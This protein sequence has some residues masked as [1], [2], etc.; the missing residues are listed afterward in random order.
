LCFGRFSRLPGLLLTACF[1]DFFLPLRQGEGPCRKEV[2]VLTPP[3][4]SKIP[5]KIVKKGIKNC[6]QLLMYAPGMEK[7]HSR[8]PRYRIFDAG[9]HMIRSVHM[10]RCLVA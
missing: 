6:P 8:E 10:N 3:Y 5:E 4:P 7:N 1:A 2:I 9:C